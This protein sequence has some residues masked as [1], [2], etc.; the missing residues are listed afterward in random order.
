MSDLGN[1]LP[2]PQRLAIAYTPSAIRN[3]F[4]LL[5]ELDG[6]F[7]DIV[8]NSSEILIGQMKFA[9]WRESIM[10]APGHGPTGEP[11]LMRLGE[12]PTYDIRSELELL[13]T[14]W[15]ELLLAERD[16]DA[17]ARFAH[18]RGMAVFDG[19][20]RLIGYNYDVQNLGAEWA[21][22]DLNGAP[23]RRADA[24]QLP[25]QRALRPL[26]ILTLSVRNVTGPRL[27]WHALTGL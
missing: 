19:Y 3:A 14:A 6:K 1:G 26:T 12:L 24:T 15:E 27:I 5:L 16:F 25:R 10:T 13:L 8:A 20:T 4:A 7:R 22:A 17:P 11:L 9:W 23:N 2:P 18:H 21:L